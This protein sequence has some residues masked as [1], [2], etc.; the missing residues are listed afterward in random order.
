[1][2]RAAV[3]S[4]VVALV[5][6]VLGM[7]GAGVADGPGHTSLPTE[8]P[9]QTP[10]LGNGK[11]TSIAQVGDT[12]VVGGTFSSITPPAG[13]PVAADR[14]AAFDASTGQLVPG[15]HPDLNGAVEDVMPG[16][17]PDTV[18]LA[19]RF[20]RVDGQQQSRVTL[21]DLGTG[22]VV[23]GFSPPAMNSRVNAIDMA[24]GRLVVGGYFTTAGGQPHGGLAMLDPLTGALDPVMDIDVSGHHNY[25]GSGAQGKVGVR[26]LA[27][28]TAGDRIAVI[29]NFTD[30]EGL[31]RDQAMVLDVTPGDVVVD[32]D[33]RTRRFEPAC[34]SWAF[35]SYVRG[36]SMSPDDS[37]FVVATTGGGNQG[38]LCDAVSRFAVDDTGQDIQPTW[39]SYSGGD[40]LWGIEATENAVYVGGHQRWMNN[41]FGR[42]WNAAGSVPRAGLAAL[43]PDSGVPLSWNPGRHPRGKAAFAIHATPDGVWVGS[44]TEWVGN[45]EFFRPRLAFFPLSGFG[46]A[47]EAAPTLPGEVQLAQSTTS[48]T[49]VPFDGTTVGTPVAGD[50]R[51]IAWDDVNDAFL[52]GDTLFY[53][54]DDNYLYRRTY[55]ETQTGPAERLDPYTDPEWND[56]PTGSGSSTYGGRHPDLY[57]HLDEL[58]GLFYAD[59]RIYYTRQGRSSLYWRWF[60]ADSGIVHPEV[61]TADGG[62]DW[63]DTAGMFLDGSTLYVVDGSSGDLQA[64]PFNGGPTGPASTVDDTLDWRGEAIFIGPG[65]DAPPPP[66][67]DLAFSASASKAGNNV[68]PRVTIPAA[69]QA[70]DLLV[71]VGS[72]QAN[73]NATDPPGWTRLDQAS[74]QGMDSVVWTRRATA[75]DAGTDVVTPLATRRKFTL[76]LG[77]YAGVADPGPVAAI[78]SATASQTDQ[79]RSPVVT[80]P[81]GAWVVQV[82]TDKSST[83]TAWTAPGGVMEREQA[84]GNGGGRIGALAA[85]SD[86][87]V[88][89]GSHG[90]QTATTNDI[91]GR[92]I[93]WTLALAPAP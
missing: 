58:T 18:Y 9:G 93:A 3:L 25:D 34:F 88:A 52:L 2:R 33:W 51:G 8:V 36:I 20:T 21:I 83:T 73:G 17:L 41:P 47:S 68:N 13:S 90:G 84:V 50:P 30:A 54:S 45:Q 48:L 35:D 66:T 59:D 15:F 10:G 37:Y 82:W 75:S 56:V 19:G 4:T 7:P 11:V 69:V 85:D 65:A 78:A 89:A 63:S 81:D 28:T 42:D 74:M 32:P 22:Q 6:A 16:P 70:G 38:T 77:A 61:Q 40:T 39:V 44:D 27:A 72:Y 80:A 53:A 23:P 62:L 64:V 31:P 91:S 67:N 87:P 71:L 1:M 24:G 29:G 92:S 46:P 76:V 86:A 60:N 43:D 5:L 49:R 12:V 79:H 55:T 57:R 26:G 14:V